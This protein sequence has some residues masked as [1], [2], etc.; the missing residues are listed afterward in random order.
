MPEPVAQGKGFEI[1]WWVPL[2]AGGA[3]G[4]GAY[5][6]ARMRRLA[7]PK[8]YPILRK[9]QEE[10]GG[11]LFGTSLDTRDPKEL[12]R[13]ERL[14]RKLTD[15]N[16]IDI[17][18]PKQLKKLREEGGAYWDWRTDDVPSGVV[19]P[20]I[21]P[22]K[23][24]KTQSKMWDLMQDME[25]KGI[26]AKVLQKHAPGTSPR[27]LDVFELAQKYNLPDLSEDTP[28]KQLGKVLKQY[29]DAMK[30]EFGE[31][32]I[33]KQKRYGAASSG[34]FPTEKHDLP[35]LYE[36]WDKNLRK[37]YEF[38]SDISDDA[39][40]LAKK[41]RTK[42][43]F[44]GKTIDDMIADN[45]IIQERLP[46]EEYTGRTAEKMRAAGQAPS[47][48]Y[49][50]HVI[51]GKVIPSMATPRYYPRDPRFI[52]EMWRA[53]K[54]AKWAQKNVIDKLPLE[55]RSLSYALD[56]APL[57]NNGGFR[58][59]ETNPGAASGLLDT[60]K[61]PFAQHQLHKVITGRHTRPM[62][63][64]IGLGTG[65]GTAGAGYGARAMYNARQ[66]VGGGDALPQQEAPATPTSG[67]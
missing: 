53:R 39:M 23:D 47:K 26:E 56:A 9:I 62:A 5:G 48:E 10:S 46:L 67:A 43:E 20:A 16:E 11:K 15:I 34:M 25:N 33:V 13:M 45:A 1:P 14:Y 3:A 28:R 18:D 60:R 21:G 63:A 49:R 27:T 44:R 22:G 57:Q 58:V 59:I 36:A 37:Q 12:S 24:A 41:Y 38:D 4:A 29:Q 17:T 42:D 50:L 64:M 35:E 31:G 66:N 55:H 8:K 61:N 6:L 40:E 30:K 54:A 32:Y 7:D 2:A 19:N 52:A 65:V 51:G